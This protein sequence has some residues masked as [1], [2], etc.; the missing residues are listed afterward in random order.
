MGL[1]LVVL[2]VAGCGSGGAPAA[3][4]PTEGQASGGTSPSTGT[5]SASPIKIGV[6]A[7]LSGS[8]SPYGT[9]LKMG[10]TLAAEEINKSGGILGRPVKLYIQ[11]DKTDPT[12]AAQVA[13][14]LLQQDGVDVLMGTI[15]SA[16]T[17]AEIPFAEQARKPFIYVVEGEDKTCKPGG[18]GTSPWVFGNGATPEQKFAQFVPYMLQHFG[19]TFYFVGSDYVFPHFVNGVGIKLIKQQGGKVVGEDYAPLGTSDFSAIVTKVER[20]HPKVIFSSVVGTDG[21]AFVKQLHQFGLDKTATITGFPSF[22]PAVYRGIK[23][24]ANGV[25]MVGRYSDLIKNP[26]NEAFVKA[27]RAKYNFK[28]PISGTAADGG[29]GTLMMIK[30]AMEKAGTSQGAAVAKALSGLHFDLASGPAVMSASNHIMKQHLYL[31]HILNGDY[32]IVKDLGQISHPDHQGCSR[33]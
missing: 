24:V 27:F 15:S 32:Q 12:A 19:K 26:Q 16:T 7:P 20:A 3:V 23:G 6:S 9:A 28:G 11:D 5:K 30:A 18:A 8:L 31:M 25:Y 14:R 1:V 22:S 33:K 2:V 17:L 10:V 4:K 21:V 29:Y 13:K